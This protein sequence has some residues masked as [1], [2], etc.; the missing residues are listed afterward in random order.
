ML[1]F[2]LALQ[3]PNHQKMITYSRIFE[4]IRELNEFIVHGNEE[5]EFVMIDLP[6][7]VDDQSL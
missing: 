4:R 1:S 2:I 6:S 7:E 3:S 5:F